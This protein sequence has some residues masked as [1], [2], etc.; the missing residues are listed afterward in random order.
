M[1]DT[2]DVV[3]DFA[4]LNR[5]LSTSTSG[6]WAPWRLGD[7]PLS[8]RVV[9]GCGRP[10]PDGRV[11]DMAIAAVRHLNSIFS[12]IYDPRD[13]EALLRTRAEK[14]ERDVA[15]LKHEVAKLRLKLDLVP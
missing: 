2:I 14:A 11:R 7:G 1:E 12:D 9:D 4:E 13:S 6:T 5:V 8:S 3:D 15:E 10:V